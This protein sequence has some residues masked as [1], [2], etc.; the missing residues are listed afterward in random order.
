VRDEGAVLVLFWLQD[1]PDQTP[2]SATNDIIDM[3]AAAKSGCGGMDCTVGGG[4]I[5]V[6][7]LPQVPLGIVVDSLGAP[8]VIE[9]LPSCNSVTPDYFTSILADTLAQVIAMKCEELPPMPP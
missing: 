8:A 1:E 2:A 9:D 4:A 7:C 6:G 5:D 3:I